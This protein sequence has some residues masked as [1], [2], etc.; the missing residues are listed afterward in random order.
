MY[1]WGHTGAARP[2][3]AA[4]RV[5]GYQFTGVSTGVVEA[6]RARQSSRSGRLRVK[7][8]VPRTR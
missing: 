2:S 6:A 4:G 5:T 1:R 8:N 7:A 3:E